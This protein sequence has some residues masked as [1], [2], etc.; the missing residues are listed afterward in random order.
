MDQEAVKGIGI[1]NGGFGIIFD[2]CG[3]V[4]D[5]INEKGESVESKGLPMQNEEIE[6]VIGDLTL[7][8]VHSSPGHWCIINGRR[9]WCP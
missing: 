2:S 8:Y 4:T 9:R 7:M 6:K 5:V 3:E 1:P